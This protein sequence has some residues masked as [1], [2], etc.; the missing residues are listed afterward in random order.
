MS[1]CVFGGAIP[2]VRAPYYTP[3]NRVVSSFFNALLRVSMHECACVCLY[4]LLSA[5]MHECVVCGCGESAIAHIRVQ[6]KRLY[7][8][9]LNVSA[10]ETGKGN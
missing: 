1:A 4:V 8:F 6:S 7:I 10:G 3:Q 9:A 5:S 2:S